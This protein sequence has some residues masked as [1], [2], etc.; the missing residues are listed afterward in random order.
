[1]ASELTSEELK[2]KRD[3]M[4]FGFMASTNS[5]DFYENLR[6]NIDIIDELIELRANN[7]ELAATVKRLEGE[8]A[9]LKKLIAD[10]LEE[11]R[12]IAIERDL[13]D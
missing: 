2:E 11:R 1:M 8:N 10:D 13:L 3:N 7:A 9:G 4:S 6:R 5:P 12:N